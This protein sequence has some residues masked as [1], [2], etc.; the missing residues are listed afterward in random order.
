[1]CAAIALAVGCGAGQSHDDDEE[2][3]DEDHEEAFS[4]VVEVSASAAER[5]GIRIETAEESA[6]FGGVEVPAEIQL[7]PDRT[8]HVSSIVQGQ[9]AEVAVSIGAPCGRRA[10]SAP[11]F[12]S[13]ATSA[14]ASAAVAG[15]RRAAPH[16]RRGPDGWPR[17]PH[18]CRQAAS[19]SERER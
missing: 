2:H 5:A 15:S 9:I 8:A 7:D 16:H 10:E 6:L 14:R 3:G 18:C 11:G 13:L 12:P 1:M 4:E 19:G 17:L